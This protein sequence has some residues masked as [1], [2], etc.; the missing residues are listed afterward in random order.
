[1]CNAWAISTLL[2]HQSDVGLRTRIQGAV[3]KLD[4]KSVSDEWLQYIVGT[5]HSSV[6]LSPPVLL[7]PSQSDPGVARIVILWRGLHSLVYCSLCERGVG[8]EGEREREKK[9]E[10]REVVRERGRRRKEGSKRNLLNECKY[11]ITI[12]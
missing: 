4:G 6:T 9:E 2:T 3:A 11:T 7:I 1:M 12:N 8:R 5:I 10:K